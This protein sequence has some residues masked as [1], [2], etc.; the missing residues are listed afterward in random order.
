MRILIGGALAALALSFGPP[1]RA[2]DEKIDPKKLVGTWA[3]ENEGAGATVF[4]ELSKDGK[5]ALTVREKKVKD[6]QVRGTYKLD[7]NKLVVALKFG[8]KEHKET[9]TVLTV[10]D[11]ELIIKDSKGK[12]E[13]YQRVD[14]REK[15]EIAR[16]PRP[17]SPSASRPASRRS[18]RGS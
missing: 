1:A 4:L 11:D 17:T 3:V 12:K 5:A 10:G 14:E 6:I 7:G 15:D 18:S 9:L 13:K 2:G 16:A 8:D